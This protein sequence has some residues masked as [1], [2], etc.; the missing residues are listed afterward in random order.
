M[1]DI[2]REVIMTIQTNTK[3]GFANNLMV[4]MA[5]LAIVVAIVLVVAWRYVF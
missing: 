4:Q 3:G 2:P 1:T 5:A